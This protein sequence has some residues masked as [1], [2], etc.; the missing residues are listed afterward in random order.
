MNPDMMYLQQDSG[1]LSVSYF[2]FDTDDQ[3]G[4]YIDYINLSLTIIIVDWL[5]AHIKSSI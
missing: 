4:Y 5:L 3:S 2:K 1:F